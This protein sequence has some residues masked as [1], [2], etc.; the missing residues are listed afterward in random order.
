MPEPRLLTFERSIRV[1]PAEAWRAFTQ[2]TLLRD[3]LCDQS[4]CDP[5]QGGHVFLQWKDGKTVTGTY[6]R[7]D[8]PKT[9]AFTWLSPGTL[10]AAQVQLD[11]HPEGE[12]MR[13]AL[14]QSGLSDDAVEP[15]RAFWPEALD[16]LASVLNSGID[17]RLARRPRLGIWMEDE[18]RPEK[19][20]E[21]GVPV[22]Q[23]VLL[24]GTAE[25]SGAQAAGLQK[26]D[27]L[28]ALNGA[29]LANPGSFDTALR[30]LKAGDRPIV[31][32]YRGGEKHSV[33]L[34]LGSFPIPNVPGTGGELADKVRSLDGEILSAMR[35]QL[36]GLSETQAEKRPSEGEWSVKELVAHFILCERDY[37]SWVAAMLNDRPVEDWLE[38]RPN[39]QPRIQALTARF[40]T[41]ADLLDE[42]TKSQEETV[43]MIAAI[44]GEFT[45][46][47]KH[48]FRRLA[49]WASEAMPGH[50]YEEHK[51]QFQAAIDL[52]QGG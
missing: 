12:G 26:D 28:V 15:L 29:V 39:V 46:N 6:T 35:Q 32:Y 21:L 50:Y 24:A 3:W 30:G 7:F 16:N 40:G 52:N 8:P 4:S 13:L 2:A 48:L 38:M 41:L 45:A 42:F 37:Q 36:A 47:R 10:G 19:A 23:G 22:E 25:H 49:S 18:L 1:S 20:R 43:A 44:P 17:Q 34:E 51:G 11:F 27:V 5:R 9:L 14:V 31:E 33:P